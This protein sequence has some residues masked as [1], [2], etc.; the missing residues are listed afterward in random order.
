MLFLIVFFNICTKIKEVLFMKICLPATEKIPT[1][2][3][4]G[5]SLPL[6]VIVSTPETE[7]WFYENLINIYIE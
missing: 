1:S 5:I 6:S 4:F 3:Y 2:S 7:A